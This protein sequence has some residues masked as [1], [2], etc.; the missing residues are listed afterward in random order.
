MRWEKG[1]DGPEKE[2]DFRCG[3]RKFRVG[4]LVLSND[5]V[6]GDLTGR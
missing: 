4:A 3:C 6:W 2:L 5:K 1:I